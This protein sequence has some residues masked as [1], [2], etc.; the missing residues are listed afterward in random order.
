[1][2]YMN[3]IKLLSVLLCIVVLFASCE[4]NLDNN[5]DQIAADSDETESKVEPAP[6]PE[7]APL[8]GIEPKFNNFF[9]IVEREEADFGSIAERVDG[10]IVSYDGEMNYFVLKTEDIDAKNNVTEVYKLYNAVSGEVALTFS[11][12]YFNGD[13]DHFS[14]NDLMIK[15][16]VGFENMGNGLFVEVDNSV[17]YRSSYLEVDVQNVWNYGES[18][19][20]VV[21]RTAK[22]TPFDESVRE[23][24]P[25][26]C[27]YQIATKYQY[28]DVYGALIAES[29]DQLYVTTISNYQG[30][31]GAVRFGAVIAYFDN[32]TCKLVSADANF[33]TD[34]IGGVYEYENDK[35]GYNLDGSIQIADIGYAGYIEIFDKSQGKVAYRYY[36]NDNY[37]NVT[38][39]LLHNGDVLIQYVNTVDEKDPHNCYDQFA[40]R[41]QNI[42]HEIFSVKDGKATSVDLG[43]IFYDVRDGEKFCEEYLEYYG[44][45]VTANARNMAYAAP[46]DKNGIGEVNVYVLDN[47]MSILYEYEKLVPEHEIRVG[48]GLGVEF[49]RNG[50]YLVD[51]DNV[52]TDKAI[53]KADGTVRSYIPDHMRVIGDYVCDDKQIYDY[54][55]NPIFDLEETKFEVWGELFGE[56]ILQRANDNTYDPND[57]M[58][59]EHSYYSVLTKDEGSDYYYASGAYPLHESEIVEYGDD[60]A[61]VKRA[62]DGKYVFLSGPNTE[63]L[64]T[65]N[66]MNVFSFEGGYIVITEIEGQLVLYKI[67]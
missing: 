26:G 24:Y 29:N 52:V 62:P 4:K 15:E 21:V 6:L 31:L 36:F 5:E 27:I 23:E 39:F 2:K 42:V 57:P 50:D 61:V 25:E 55:L 1:M 16:T 17:K 45:G 20:Y 35:Y 54:D 3:I 46:F 64:V 13:Y 34:K 63:E 53:V 18:I 66:T 9:E 10:E 59:S 60:Y 11:N 44:I 67:N 51:L 38:C 40:G 19:P 30:K 22:V 56:L 14:W 43:Y 8:T 47:D 32:E 49:L 7:E 65:Y 58:Y 28:Y 48:N 12:T 37:R 41:Y 33:D